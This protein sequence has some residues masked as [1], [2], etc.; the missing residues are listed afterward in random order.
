MR[1]IVQQ[2][3]LP[4]DEALQEGRHAIEVLAQIGQFVAPPPHAGGNAHI[5]IAT[6]GGVKALA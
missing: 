6:G 3:L 1:N 5:E 4:L 2:A